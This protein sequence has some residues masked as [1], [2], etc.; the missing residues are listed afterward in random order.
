MYFFQ[1]IPSAELISP[2]TMARKPATTP[3]LAYKGDRLKP[4]RAFCQTARLGSVSRAAE[5]LFVSQPAVT[6]QLQALERELGMPLLERSGRRMVPTREGEVLYEL[7]LP[8]VEGLDALP[9][10]FRQRVRGLD[11][12]ELNIAANSTTTL[13]LLPRL[14]AAFRA[15]HPGVR[16]VLHSAITADGAELVRNNTVDLTFGSMVDVPADID[17]AP[18]YR[19]DQVLIA[20]R[21][22]PLASHAG[23]SLEDIAAHDLILPPRRQVTLR[24][25]DQVFQRSRVPYHVALEVDGWEVIKQY[26]AMGMGISI[27]SSACVNEADAE[28][29]AVRPLGKLFPGRSYGVIM[30]KGKLLSAPARAFIDLVKPDLFTRR[31]YYD[32]GHSER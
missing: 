2:E 25:V 13:Y 4:L 23:P 27:I 26:V 14:I 32:S 3:R 1:C 28:N 8:L 6:Q 16:L 20:P 15:A 7:A 18:V 29:L 30:R 19:F 5:A 22:H 11:A 31:D 21:G 12:G 10:A 9:D 24:L 17:Y